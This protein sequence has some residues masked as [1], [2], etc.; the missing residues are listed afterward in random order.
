MT[1]SSRFSND[2]RYRD[3]LHPKQTHLTPEYVL[4]PVRDS[5]GGIELDP[6]TEPDNPIGAERFYTS[7]DD[8]LKCPWDADTIWCN[9]PYGKAREPWVRKCISSGEL[10]SRVALL[11]PSHTDTRI[12]QEAMHSADTVVFVKG[13]VKFG[14]PRANGRQMAASHPS[15]IL[16]WNTALSGCMGLGL[17]VD[18]RGGLL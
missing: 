5:L 17:V 6:C 2:L 7:E 11:I 10:G 12:F 13:R 18:L 16:G 3:G 1:A 4:D 14:V 15:A 9:P 8:G